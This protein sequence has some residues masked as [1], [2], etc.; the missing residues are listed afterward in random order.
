MLSSIV[1]LNAIADGNKETR[2]LVDELDEKEKEDK[3]L[4]SHDS[5]KVGFYR[6]STVL[7]DG[8][9]VISASR[10]SEMLPTF[11]SINLYSQQEISLFEDKPEFSTVNTLTSFD[12]GY[13]AGGYENG[14][15]R[16]WDFQNQTTIRELKGNNEKN[17]VSRL[18]ELPNDDRLVSGHL[19]ESDNGKCTGEIHLWD[20]KNETC[21]AKVLT[22]LPVRIL[23]RI[24]NYLV[25]SYNYGFDIFDINNLSL[26]KKIRNVRV[27]GVFN[28]SLMC[29]HEDHPNK[30][31]FIHPI[32]L[33]E[34]LT[35]LASSQIRGC[36]I[37][38][39]RFLAYCAGNTINIYDLENHTHLARFKMSG[40]ISRSDFET[41]RVLPDGR[42]VYFKGKEMHI[43]AISI[44]RQLL[45]DTLK[46]MIEENIR[47]EAITNFTLPSGLSETIINY[48]GFFQANPSKESKELFTRIHDASVKAKI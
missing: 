35:I 3:I 38:Y 15:I 41:L 45:H 32:T 37:I 20:W 47:P 44:V 10:S 30:I 18:L 22:E 34:N 16:I 28:G 25:S 46:Q 43:C 11:C 40:F 1:V 26:I 14:L 21:I 23:A 2:N 7:S 42:L 12:N 4:A 13:L 8:S 5:Y 17:T 29:S 24:D 27:F 19:I 6:C 36:A 48:C 33:E 39:Y 31:S 9:I